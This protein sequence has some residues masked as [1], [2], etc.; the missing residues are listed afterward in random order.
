AIVVM[1]L[2]GWAT[3]HRAPRA[4]SVIVA[5][6]W[7]VLACGALWGQLLVLGVAALGVMRLA[8]LVV[9]ALCA[10]MILECWRGFGRSAVLAKL[11]Q[12]PRPA[13]RE[14]TYR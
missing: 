7:L 4:A 1:G 5:L 13:A 2:V 12:I 9:V 6:Q 8:P 14:E 11:A 3:F 10:Y